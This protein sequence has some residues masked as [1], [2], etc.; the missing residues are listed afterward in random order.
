MNNQLFQV[1]TGLQI[2]Q[3]L[4]VYKIGS[5]FCC[6]H[7]SGHKIRCRSDLDNNIFH[8]LVFPYSVYRYDRYR[9]MAIYN[10]FQTFFIKMSH[11]ALS[12]YLIVKGHF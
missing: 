4:P 12:H 2:I 8:N 7:V 11:L 6:L 5:V 9:F 10:E 3:A 1:A